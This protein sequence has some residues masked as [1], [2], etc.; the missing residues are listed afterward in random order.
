[1]HLQDPALFLSVQI[2]FDPQG[3]GL[4]GSGLGVSTLGGTE[5]PKLTKVKH[6]LINLHVVILWQATKA[7]PVYPGSHWQMALWL[8]AVQ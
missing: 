2:A 8:V 6:S 3:E 5:I 7:L 4:Q 1:M